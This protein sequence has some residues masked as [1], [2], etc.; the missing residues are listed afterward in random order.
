MSG[1]VIWEFREKI[2]HDG[3]KHYRSTSFT[4]RHLMEGGFFTMD[5]ELST[6]LISAHRSLG[7]LDGMIKYMPNRGIIRDLMILKECYYSRLVDYDEPSLYVVMASMNADKSDYSH[8]VHIVT[9]YKR[10]IGRQ[11]GSRTLPDTC[12]IALYGEEPEEKCIFGKHQFKLAGGIIRLLLWM[13]FR[14]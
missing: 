13:S 14:P 5:D 7:I 2:I 10:A 11:V 1:H 9:A 12:T 8:I 6:L 4:P 3:K